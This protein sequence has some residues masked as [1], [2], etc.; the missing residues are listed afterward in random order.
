MINHYF[1]LGIFQGIL[2]LNSVAG[3]LFMLS[4]YRHETFYQFNESVYTKVLGEMTVTGSEVTSSIV[5]IW[6]PSR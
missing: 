2:Q 6:Q 5:Q 4:N 1:H 3:C